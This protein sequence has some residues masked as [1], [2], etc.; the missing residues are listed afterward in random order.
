MYV[1]IRHAA[2]LEKSHLFLENIF[3]QNGIKLCHNYVP[4]KMKIN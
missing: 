2:L 3:L 1:C 4:Q